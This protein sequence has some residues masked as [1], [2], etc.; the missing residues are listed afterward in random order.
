MRVHISFLYLYSFTWITPSSQVQLH[1]ILTLQ[2]LTRCCFICRSVEY[3]A[4]VT[5]MYVKK[6]DLTSTYNL[7]TKVVDTA[8]SFFL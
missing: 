1:L 5:Y 7:K 2:N 4:E 8:V 6:N 3:H